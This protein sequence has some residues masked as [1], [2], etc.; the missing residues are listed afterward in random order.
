MTSFEINLDNT[1][2]E[3]PL[4]ISTLK[5]TTQK[6]HAST[7]PTRKLSRVEVSNLGAQFKYI[8]SQHEVKLEEILYI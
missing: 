1:D 4:G 8:Q 3:D 5:A 6:E 2:L 7:E